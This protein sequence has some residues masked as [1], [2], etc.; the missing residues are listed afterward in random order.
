MTMSPHWSVGWEELRPLRV[1]S[2]GSGEENGDIGAERAELI[3]RPWLQ[4]WNVKP[5]LCSIHQRNASPAHPYAIS[6][7]VS[8]P[9]N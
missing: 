3:A 5:A 1:S 7:T 2:L 8:G 9:P 4:S 6:S